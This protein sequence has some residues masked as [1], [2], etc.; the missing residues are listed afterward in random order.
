MSEYISKN[1]KQQISRH[2]ADCCA[3]CRNAYVLMPVT[4]ECEHIIPL[5]A[6]GKTVFE[7]LCLACPM[8][9]RYKS[10]HQQA[11]DPKTEEIVSLFH[12]H[13]QVWTEHFTWNENATE[14]IGLTAVGR[15]TIST[16]KM[17]RPDLVRVR[18]MWVEL[19][20]HPPS[21]E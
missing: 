20:E 19:G 14:I 17:N 10:N 18:A 4:F 8:C 12:P 3:Y 13:L 1:L 21:L 5:S 11:P 6:G 2:F 7:N 16:L 15:A 9:N